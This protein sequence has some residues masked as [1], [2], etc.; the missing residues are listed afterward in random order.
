MAIVASDIVLRLSVV[1]GA[2]GDSTAQGNVNN[3]LGK[4]V[5]TTAMGTGANSLYD[6][7]SGAENT[8]STVDY[9]CFFVLN[10]HA[11][12]TMLATA[13]YLSSEVAGG[14]SVAIA[15]DNI[16]ASAKGS[17][18]AQAAQIANETTAPTGVGTFSSPTTRAAGL[19]I[20]DLTPGQVKGV[21]VRRT[22]ANSAALDADGV[23]FGI[24]C[25]T[26]A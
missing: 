7:I 9:R 18:S 17:A 21:W 25:D 5:S 1:T 10:N 2:A 12:L 19:L 22:A 24:A 15:L 20:G 6:D 3:S 14:A 11:T 26:A 13:V 8:A 4:Y 16:A 23:T